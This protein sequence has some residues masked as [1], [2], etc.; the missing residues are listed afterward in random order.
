MPIKIFKKTEL[1]ESGEILD[2]NYVN[3]HSF[4]NINAV[5]ERPLVPWRDDLRPP[6]AEFGRCVITG[7]FGSC[8]A[9]D[10]GD[11]SV[12][13]PDCSRGVTLDNP[14][15]DTN[16]NYIENSGE[17]RFSVWRPH[18]IQQQLLISED[19]L[20]RL[21]DFSRNNESVIPGITP[22][23][24]YIWSVLNIDGSGRKQFE[25][26]PETD[27]E[28]EVNTKELGDY[29]QVAQITLEH[30]YNQ[31]LPT[32]TFVASTG[33]IFKNGE[34][35]DLAFDAPIPEGALPFYSRRVMHVWGSAMQ[36][37]SLSRSFTLGQTTVLQLIGWRVGGVGSGDAPCCI[38]A[39]DEQGGWRPWQYITEAEF[40]ESHKD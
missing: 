13:S 35:L 24:E 15:F 22:N 28:V 9:I 26:D 27:E 38:I 29:S 2:S 12:N 6:S 23:L 7:E 11:L 34:E 21:L 19:G 33:K 1:S 14:Q 4:E 10:L 3:N 20:N 32:Y 8:V 37:N 40:I 25:I 18:V 30:H 36:Y 16:G 39:I 31:A 17:V 5:K